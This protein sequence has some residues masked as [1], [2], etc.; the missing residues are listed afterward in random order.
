MKEMKPLLLDS[1][2]LTLQGLQGLQELTLLCGF[3]PATRR[4]WL[5]HGLLA[6]RA[7]TQSVTACPAFLLTPTS[8]VFAGAD[9]KA[10]TRDG[11]TPIVISISMNVS[12][13]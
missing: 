13:L 7:A 5:D 2:E 8:P 10:R 9:A 6:H 3:E 4:V 11:L 1:V 12:T